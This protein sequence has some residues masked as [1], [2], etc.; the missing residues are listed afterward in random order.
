MRWK[1]RAIAKETGIKGYFNKADADDLKN[2]F[3]V[4]QLKT[5][6]RTMANLGNEL[7]T[8]KKIC[9]FCMLMLHKSTLVNGF[10]CNDCGYGERHGMCPNLDSTYNNIIH[11]NARLGMSICSIIGKHSIK[12]KMAEILE[13]KIK[14]LFK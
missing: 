3:T 2:N 5:A 9:P 13:K 4:D 8:D 7:I 12:F 14:E 1:S 11:Y 10:I 6:V